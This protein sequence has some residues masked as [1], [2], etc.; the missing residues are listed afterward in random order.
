MDFQAWAFALALRY[1]FYPDVRLEF[2]GNAIDVPWESFRFIVVLQTASVFLRELDRACTMISDHNMA[3]G[4]WGKV[5]CYYATLFSWTSHLSIRIQLTSNCVKI[6]QD[7]AH[8]STLL[9]QGVTAYLPS[10]SSR[11]VTGTT[12]D[13]RRWWEEQQLSAFSKM[14][15]NNNFCIFSDCVEDT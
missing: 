2:D 5:C 11:L 10:T 7:V 9:P 12:K 8:H 15:Q 6:A 1:P 4:G 13:Q 14:T 3:D